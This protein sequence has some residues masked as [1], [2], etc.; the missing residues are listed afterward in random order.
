MVE[1]KECGKTLGIFE[2]YQ[3]PT[4]GKNHSLCGHCFDNVNESVNKW[5]DFILNN[6]FNN[7][8]LKNNIK[9]NWKNIIPSI[10]QRRNIIKNKSAEIGILFKKLK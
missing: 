8:I 7:N 1:C 4:M 3:H 10:N 9:M 6:S 5:R 2:G